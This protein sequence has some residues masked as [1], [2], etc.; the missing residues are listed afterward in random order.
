VI[1]LYLLLAFAGGAALPF[2]AGIN[3]QLADWLGSPVRAAFVSFLVGT[4]VLV[5]AAA[6]V[7][8]PLPS[9]G[10]L[11]DAPWWVW[12][13]GAL[14]AFYVAA[15]IVTAPR[16]GAATLI[17]LVVAGQ[18]LASLIV[19]HYGWVGFEAQQITAGRIAGMVLV[20]AGVALVRFT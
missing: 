11:S 9:G 3:A 10:R 20:G 16:L 17:A 15:S 5:V 4:I 7:F 13:G 19:D 6:L 18:A 2:Q 8:R 1:W 12:V 14:G